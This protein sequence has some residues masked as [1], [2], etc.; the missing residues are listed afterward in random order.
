MTIQEKTN[1]KKLQRHSIA[2]ASKFV[3]HE[4][5]AF[6]HSIDRFLTGKIPE[7]TFLEHRLRHG[8][9]G[10]RQ[11]GV[12]MIRSKLPLGLLGPEQLEAFAD[13]TEAY[14]SGIAHLTTRQDI[15]VHFVPLKN[16]PD[17]MRVLAK[18]EMTSREACGNVVRNITASEMAG[19]EP[20]D[21]FDVTPYGMALAQ[22]LLR[23]PDGQSLGR[24]F[25]VTLSGTFDPRFNH[26]PIHD[27]GLTAQIRDGQ[28]GFHVLVGGGLG[29]VPHE[30]QVLTEFLPEAELFPTAVAI[31]RL[32]ARH[33]EKKRRARARM[34]FLVAQ[35]GIERFRA[36]VQRERDELKP[37]PEWADFRDTSQDWTDQP[38]WGPGAQLPEP[39]DKQ[40]KQ[41]LRTN[42]YPQKQAGYATVK[43]RVP[44][45]DLIP[46]QLRSLAGLLR[47]HVGDSLRLGVDQSIFLRFVSWDRLPQVYDTLKSMDLGMTRA[48]GLGDTVTCPGAD[49]C[50]LG[51]TT[52]RSLHRHIEDLLED[53]S[54]HPRLEQ[55]RIKVS[56]C[57]SSCAQHQL[58][59]IGFFGA[60]RTQNGVTAPHFMLVLGGQ[61]GGWGGGEI[62][63]GFG[64]PISKIPAIQVGAAVE[65]LT[66]FFL[67]ESE[68]DEGW[69]EFVRRQGRATFKALLKEISTL[70][71]FDAA[72]DLYREYGAEQTFTMVRGIGECGGAVVLAG[73]LLLI[74]AD[75]NADLAL[76]RFDLNGPVSE[77]QTAAV[78][79][80]RLAA[81]ALL[82]TQEVSVESL[83]DTASEFKTRF[84]DTGLIYE[85]VG[86]YFLTAARESSDA[87][88]GDRIRR[89]SVEA[90]LFVEE[91]HSIIAKLQNPRLAS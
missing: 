83:D 82:S 69:S 72:P 71:S 15:Q 86:H 6:D 36:E 48:G 74:Q 79:A 28:R 55:L 24:K 31:L 12:H 50:K 14:S 8:V 10:Q 80:M 85:G 33:G 78:D 47:G 89:L 29:A 53:L 76:E 87:I 22:F 68:P 7:A 54:E 38:L 25:K 66:S 49:S 41:W 58:A 26:G 63:S 62:G 46:A 2:G 84:Y 30:A 5:D 65:R 42:V 40:E 27:L 23:H 90:G 16:T 57:P 35:W 77:I 52:P 32:F 43:I 21:V 39:R 45:G 61:A 4:V 3:A 37:Q 73:D 34:K 51:I 70:P 18:A 20:D 13:L 17:L 44:R 1:Y 19:V 67:E 60:A 75:Q 56:G 88:T 9:Y 11:D 81:Q 59:D 91:V 64:I